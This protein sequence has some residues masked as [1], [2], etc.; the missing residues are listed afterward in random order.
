MPER[1]GNKLGR[2]FRSSSSGRELTVRPNGPKL[3]VAGVGEEEE[4]GA[5]NL[6]QAVITVSVK[7]SHDKFLPTFIHR[8]FEVQGRE[9]LLVHYSWQELSAG[10]SQ[11]FRAHLQE[12]DSGRVV[13]PVTFFYDLFWERAFSLCPCLKDIFKNNMVRQSRCLV[14][15]ACECAGLHDAVSCGRNLA[16]LVSAPRP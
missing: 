16:G 11:T 9:L 2:L 4:D 5:V 14:R 12:N 15:M 8:K 7:K 3:K 1:S 6:S 10:S 13:T